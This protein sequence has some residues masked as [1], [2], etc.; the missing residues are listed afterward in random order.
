MIKLTYKQRFYFAAVAVVISCI[1]CYFIVID[2][3]ILLVRDYNAMK[4]ELVNYDSTIKKISA[5]KKDVYSLQNKIKKFNSNSSDMQDKIVKNIGFFCEQHGILIKGITFPKVE[6]GKN[7]KLLETRVI[8]VKGS[9]SG[10]LQLAYNIE[11]KFGVG[12]ISSLHFFLQQ[13]SQTN[14]K[15]LFAYIYLQS[16]VS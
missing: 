10:I 5:V 9:Y 4:E 12:R 7:V 8:T 11:Q 6:Q 1:A 2:K 3:T 16:V 14:V 15:E 13:N